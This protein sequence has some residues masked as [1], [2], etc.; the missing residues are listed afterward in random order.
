MPD[1]LRI[2]ALSNN[3]NRTMNF[4]ILESMVVV[5]DQKIFTL[6]EIR[7][8]RQAAGEFCRTRYGGHLAHVTSET[9]MQVLQTAM[10]ERHVT[11]VWIGASIN[12][13]NDKSRKSRKIITRG[14]NRKY[15]A[16]CGI[17]T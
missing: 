6:E 12:L 10:K 14:G 16:T 11:D 17:L 7:M 4:I 8:P 13:N 3:N 15:A 5:A 1:Y 2:I 9:E